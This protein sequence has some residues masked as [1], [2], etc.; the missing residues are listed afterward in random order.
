MPE[1]RICSLCNGSGEGQ[2]SMSTCQVCMGSGVR[3][4]QVDDNDPYDEYDD[5]Y[6]D[7]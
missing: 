6:Y 4:R 7:L 5:D 1:E 3:E 2:A